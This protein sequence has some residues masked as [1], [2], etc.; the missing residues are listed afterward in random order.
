MP[1]CVRRLPAGRVRSQGAEEGIPDDAYKP[2]TGDDKE[3]AKHFAKRNKAEKAGQGLLD[4]AH[5]GGALPPARLAAQMD[6]LRHLPEDTMADVE[7]KRRKFAPMGRRSTPLCHQVACDLYV[8]AFLLPKTGGVPASSGSGMIPTT[9]TIR[10]R[11]GGGTI[12]G[13]LEAA[14]VDAAEFARAF[15][16]PLE[17]PEVIIGKGGFDVVLGNP[18]W[19]RIKLQEQEFFASRDPDIASAPNA[20]ART[21]MIKALADAE[22]DSPARRLHAAFEMTKRIAEASSVFFTS[23][24]DEDP[25]KI[26]PAKVGKA[27]R[28]PWTGRGDVNTYALFAEHF[29]NLTRA[30]GRSGLIVPTGIAT[31]ATTAPF[32]AHVVDQKRLGA[33]FSFENEE[34]IFSGIH[35]AMKFCLLVIKEPSLAPA[36]FVFFA[37]Q[38]AHI[39]DTRRRFTLSPAQIE[40]INPNTKTA[41]IFRARADAEL[42]AAIYDRV[43]V[44]IY[45]HGS[46]VYNV[47]GVSFMRMFDMSNDSG[48]FRTSAQLA[49]EGRVR[50]GADWV[51]PVATLLPPEG[52]QPHKL[53]GGLK[54]RRT[55]Y[56]YFRLAT[57]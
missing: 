17:F 26:D 7:A 30:N 16:W 40:L 18:P 48:Q 11:M 25:T 2:L 8:A 21:K 42:T 55:L 5:G 24:K 47:W 4:F 56:W 31:D 38:V 51:F 9:A 36:E 50:D 52:D 1:I 12:Y 15:H 27:R 53:E 46:T 54:P 37:R 41:P 45:E 43:P 35:H 49:D 44:L 3:T 22:A 34:M 57:D 28:Y 33:I 20:A 23:P 10:T 32:F 39:E 13:P 14:A 29:L 19:E 6:D